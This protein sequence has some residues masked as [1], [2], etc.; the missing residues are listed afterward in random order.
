MS[1]PRPSLDEDT[2]VDAVG[3]VL[4][5]TEPV[6]DDAVGVAYAAVEMDHL[7]EELATL[8][9]DSF[10]RDSLVALRA[11]EDDTRLLSFSTGRYTV[12]LELRT[13]RPVLVGQVTPQD[14]AGEIVV[15]DRDGATARAAVDELGRFRV[16]APGGVI[17]LRLVGK[18]VTPW[19]GR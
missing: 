11:G 2:L 14:D 18:L 6:P 17:R 13:D 15:E 19:I 10:A 5:H 4:E 16:E 9:F 3:R 1:G 12:D 8:T 7:A